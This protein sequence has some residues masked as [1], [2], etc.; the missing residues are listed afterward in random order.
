MQPWHELRTSRSFEC[1]YQYHRGRRSEVR[2]AT[3]FLLCIR[4]PRCFPTLRAEGPS[5]L[6]SCGV[7][8][9]GCES[10]CAST[11]EECI[12]NWYCIQRLEREVLRLVA[13]KALV[14]ILPPYGMQKAQT[15][16]LG[17][18]DNSWA[19]DT[20]AKHLCRLHPEGLIIEHYTGSE[21][22]GTRT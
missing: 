14:F 6:R 16:S 21:T 20:K 9:H 5:S 22:C 8:S 17:M 4:G 15:S 2:S 13:V 18:E 1:M 3:R 7:A 19:F 10:P 11:A 12:S